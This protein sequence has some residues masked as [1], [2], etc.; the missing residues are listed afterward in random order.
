MARDPA[1]PPKSFDQILAWL[2]PDRDEA[3]NIYIQLRTDLT[4]IFIWNHCADPDGLT[5]EV[6]DRVA[7]K[8]HDVR[9]NFEGDPRL[10]FYGVARNLIKEDSKRT[11]K[12]VCLEDTD[13]PVP[14]ATVEDESATVREE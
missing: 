4:K 1:I 3:A 7:R 8:V 13:L 5:D 14:E 2:H 6:F 12:H 11:K 9:Q 10:F